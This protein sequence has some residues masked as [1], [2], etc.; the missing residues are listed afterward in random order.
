MKGKYNVPVGLSDHSGETSVAYS[1]IANSAD[2]LEFHVVFN[3]KMFGPDT[4]SSLDF[5]QLNQVVKFRNDNFM[6]E[7][8][9]VDKDRMEKELSSIKALF[10]KSLVLK[11]SI[12]KGSII[13][14][15]HL[16]AKK[17]SIGI[18]VQKIDQCIGRR[19]NDDHAAGHIL[20]W[21]DL[22]S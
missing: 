8:N 3:K 10:N 2:I 6:I 22:E 13:K 18:P 20:N 16:T 12:K 5:D 19:I 11:K 17:P 1:A 9:P 4:K 21:D 14:K 15:E 7:S